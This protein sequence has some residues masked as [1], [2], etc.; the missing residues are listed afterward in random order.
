MASTAAAAGPA[1]LTAPLGL[2]NGV[3]EVEVDLAG[4]A[5]AAT[6]FLDG[7]EACAPTASEPT[8]RVDLGQGLHVHLLELVVEGAAGRVQRVERWLNRPG[9]E[10]DLEIELA[11]RPI[12]DVCGGRL[13]WH[14]VHGQ[15]P[16][17]LEVE[18][19]GEHI[20]VSAENRIFGYPCAAAGATEVV[21]AA[22]VFPD[23]RRASSVA[24]TGDTGK[25]AGAG[26]QSIVL[27]GA[28]TGGSPC[29]S[30][31]PGR[32]A[33]IEGFEV[34]F[35]LDPTVD[36][37]ALAGLGD[38]AGAGL[39]AASAWDRASSAFSDADNL[40]YLRPDSALLR[41]DGFSR[42]RETWLGSFFQIGSSPLNTGL[43]LSDAVATAGLVAGALPHRR[44]VVLVLGSGT[45]RD[46]SRF[47]SRQARSYLAEVGVPLVV[48]RTRDAVDD[49]WSTGFEVGSLPEFAHAIEAVRERIDDQCVMWFPAQMDPQQ[50]AA[51]LPDGT[52]VA[53]RRD[54]GPDAGRTVWR[55]AEATSAVSEVRPVSDE[56]VARGKVEV[57]AVEV[58][59][60][61]Q[62]EKGDPVTDLT[63]GEFQVAEDG[64]SV[65][66]LQLEPILALDRVGA[67]P[68]VAADERLPAA[69][70][71]RKIVPVSVYVERGLAGA[72]DIVPAIDA[73]TQQVD[74]LTSLGPVDVVVA[75]SSVDTVLEGAT[76]PEVVRRAL[77]NVVKLRSHGHAIERIRTNYVRQVLDYPDRGIAR[78][79]ESQTAPITTSTPAN[80]LRIKTMTAARTS[81]FEEDALLRRTMARMN[82]W[83]LGLQASGPRLLFLVGTGFDEDPIDFYV[84][85]LEMKD[86]SLGTAARAEFVRYNQATRVDSVGRELAAAGWMVVPLATR[87]AGSQRSAAE[88]SG[89]D[90]FQSFLTDR[91]DGPY[92]SD[93]EFMLLDPLGS[94]QHLA[95]PSGGKVV[96]GGRGLNKL[97]SESSGWYRLSYQVARAPDGA[98]HEV[99]VTSER[100]GVEI[101]NT[102]VVVSGT[103]EGRAAMR[104][105]RLLDDR[106]ATGELPVQVLV[107]PAAKNED[108]QLEASL[109]VSVDLE[110]IAP[111]F[112][113]EGARALRF[114][115]GV[116][117]GP[118][119]PFV[120]HSVV[121]A[122]GA[123]GGMQFEAPLQ[124]SGD[125]AELAVVVEDL[126]SGAW[127][128]TVSRLGE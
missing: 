99:A 65:P 13:S 17:V 118:G 29:S 28:A 76:D 72:A 5:A 98:L 114:S 36:Y 40:W 122:A 96:V 58:L 47:S 44:A 34:A 60:R 63:A 106:S 10:A 101:E 31:G 56:P 8:C 19:A 92:L 3:L 6:L 48:L 18:A 49:G 127:G 51:S 14:D 22:A 81:I 4:S 117:S 113:A 86:P 124:W 121:T 33:R 26:P 97:I 94:Q 107:G 37:A 7:V 105:R 128:G 57:T 116:R 91:T 27:E 80:E 74:W 62:D 68:P 87:I 126:G 9:R 110:S 50:I 82:D 67:P 25:S 61:A 73:L 32:P 125:D 42:G 71:A 84:R 79:G 90:T 89:R 112:T 52:A 54:A 39:D 103:S 75:E 20:P 16:S 77:E 64:H 15:R 102:G 93:V 85:F 23:G 115:I 78:E 123:V 45:A 104:L 2:V 21:A 1:I 100:A 38:R 120:S 88:F 41:L 66:V 43:R 24:L 55:R 53:G 109:T 69:A 70:P 11:S 95:A 83:A 12:G 30:T 111:L 59:V 35:V 46:Q 119:V 108:Q